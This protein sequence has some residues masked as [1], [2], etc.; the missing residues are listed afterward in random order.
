MKNIEKFNEIKI[1]EYNDITYG[2]HSFIFKFKKENY[3]LE[4]DSLSE[5]I[6]F[7]GLE[8]VHF[9]GSGDEFNLNKNLT[10]YFWYCVNSKKYNV[11][12]DKNKNY[13]IDIIK[14][15]LN[16]VFVDVSGFKKYEVNYKVITNFL[17]RKISE[18]DRRIWLLNYSNE[19]LKEIT[20]DK[21]KNIQN[22]V[23]KLESFE[24]C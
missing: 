3:E 24:D 15:Y 21:L 8:G 17:E 18:L 6:L 13:I 23:I 22:S 11:N 4:F 2:V 19:K 14:Y 9:M 20:F 10:E 16:C 5:N 12:L 7:E 1:K